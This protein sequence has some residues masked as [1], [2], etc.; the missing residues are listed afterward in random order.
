MPFSIVKKIENMSD[1]AQTTA[2]KLLG[3]MHLDSLADSPHESLTGQGL[4]VNG[5]G[6]Q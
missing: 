1:P 6:N 5:V 4:V 3:F 2:C